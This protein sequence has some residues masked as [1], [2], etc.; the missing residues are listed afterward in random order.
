[1][2]Q[3]KRKMKNQKKTRRKIDVRELTNNERT[4][5]TLLAI[6]IL[7][8]LSFKYIIDPQILKISTLESKMNAYALEV[9]ENNRIIKNS[10]VILDEKS[11]LFIEKQNI[12]KDFFKSLNQPQIIYVLNELLLKS[13]IEMDSISFSKPFME[14]LNAQ[15]IQK[16]D[17]SIPFKG[18]FSS[19]NEIIKSL[20]TE[21]RKIVINNIDIQKGEETE[22]TGNISLGVY[23]LSGIVEGKDEDLPIETTD[24]N[25]LNPFI[26][27]EGYV[28][29]SK[30]EDNSSEEIESGQAEDKPIEESIYDTY[31]AIKGD[32]ISYISKRKYGTE[33]YVDEILSLNGM[34]RSSILPIGKELKLKKK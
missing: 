23:S 17:I 24:E 1:M 3:S 27:Y 19:L 8:W 9:E 31:K 25:K 13:D 29:L 5:I 12:E 26:P 32:N 30:V 10:E 16:M 14:T 20:E 28:D 22:I 21:T 6:V 2:E 7:F 33:K 18:S 4:L 15:E 11:K 34:L